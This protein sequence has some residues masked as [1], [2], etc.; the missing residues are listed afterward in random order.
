M[1][2]GVGHGRG[3]GGMYNRRS[4]F[5][6]QILE[7][8]VKVSSY[9]HDLSVIR[10]PGVKMNKQNIIFYIIFIIDK[11]CANINISSNKR[12]FSQLK[13]QDEINW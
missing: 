3:A 13:L 12:Y 11:R 6:Y 1:A 4:L 2:W 5:Q 8:H 7:S 10:S 9:S